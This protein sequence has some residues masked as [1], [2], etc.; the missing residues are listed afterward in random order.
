M[1]EKPKTRLSSHTL[2]KNQTAQLID[3]D[4]KFDQN[5]EGYDSVK[6]SQNIQG[7]IN[8]LSIEGE[9]R[10]G[11]ES[12][13]HLKVIHSRNDSQKQESTDQSTNMIFSQSNFNSPP[14]LSNKV[15]RSIQKCNKDPLY[16]ERLIMMKNKLKQELL[17][18][19]ERKS[20]ELGITTEQA[21]EEIF[22]NDHSQNLIRDQVMRSH[23]NRQLSIDDFLEDYTDQIILNNHFYQELS[24]QMA[25][26]QTL[27]VYLDDQLTYKSKNYPYDLDALSGSNDYKSNGSQSLIFNLSLDI[28]IEVDS[29]QIRIE[30]YDKDLESERDQ[31]TKQ[32]KTL[33]SM[34]E[35]DDEQEELDDESRIFH[36][37]LGQITIDL[38]E[39]LI[40]SLMNSQHI[41]F[42]K[43]M[44]IS[45]DAITGR[46]NITPRS[47]EKQQN[48]V[49]N[50]LVQTSSK[51]TVEL[52]PKLTHQYCKRM[53]KLQQDQKLKSYDRMMD[54][55]K[56]LQDKEIK[57]LDA[58]RDLQE[59]GFFQDVGLMT[60]DMDQQLPQV[61]DFDTEQNYF[62]NQYADDSELQQMSDEQR[63][64]LLQD[65]Y[66]KY[67]PIKEEDLENTK[68]E[69][70]SQQNSL[71][72][73]RYQ[74]GDSSKMD[75]L[76]SPQ[77]HKLMHQISSF[78]YS[79][80][81][82]NN[83]L[84]TSKDLIH[85]LNDNEGKYNKGNQRLRNS[86][87]FQQ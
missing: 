29:Q 39:V 21:F 52:K 15:R 72:F 30:M 37:Q 53:I 59:I 1:S 38:D 75:Q 79:E 56:N 27:Y 32:N 65:I 42:T 85:H 28:P 44:M 51:M 36:S 34:M 78:K 74:R 20:N 62:S 48:P 73:M 86:S 17:D 50:R 9:Q 5:R 58:T 45:N 23:A 71:S 83:Q 33:D 10:N 61:Q 46:F 49:E 19:I 16:E 87:S 82:D 68:T 6:Q 4:S 35:Y 84:N 76:I 12:I 43:A 11:N 22:F 55:S 8:L 14:R 25:Q 63:Q 69:S 57:L 66:M 26:L 60:I 13:S 77:T 2:G 54:T 47:T 24:T 81:Q 18:H 3:N 80:G 64:K 41:R 7:L 40:E 31:L 70:I 67:D